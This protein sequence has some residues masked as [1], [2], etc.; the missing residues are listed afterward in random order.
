MMQPEAVMPRM[1]LISRERTDQTFWR[2]LI[3]GIAD[4]RHRKADQSV[5]QYLKRHAEDEQGR[6]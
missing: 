4:G 2:D 6:R 1:P 5:P 3:F